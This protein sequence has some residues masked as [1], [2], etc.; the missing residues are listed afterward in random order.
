M[1]A[2]SAKYADKIILTAEDPRGE[3]VKLINKEI[4]EGIQEIQ[5]EDI[6]Y[7]SIANREKAIKKALE[8]A[9]RGDIVIITGKG[10]ERSMN[11]DGKKELPWNEKE[12]I[13]K[14]LRKN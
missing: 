7:F 4:I 12:V 3:D 13:L 10:H 9:K 14:L 8:I 5:R 2:I 6:E 1:G 11:I